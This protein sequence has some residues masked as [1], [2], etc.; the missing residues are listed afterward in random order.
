MICR[1]LSMLAVLLPGL[2]FAE[3][4]IAIIIDDIGYQRQLGERAIALDPAITLAVIPRSPHAQ[5]LARQA[6]EAGREVMIHLPMSASFSPLLDPGGI[7][8]GMAPENIAAVVREAFELVPGARGLNNHMGSELTADQESMHWLM[9][10]LASHQVFFVDSR[11]TPESVAERT[12]RAHGLA[13]AGRDV[14]LDNE[15]EALDIN[16]QFNTLLRIA[17]QRG[18]AIAIG[19]PYPE[20]LEYLETIIP[21]LADAGFKLVPVS[22]LLPESPL[23]TAQANQ[24]ATEKLA[25]EASTTE[26]PDIEEISSQEKRDSRQA[27]RSGERASPP[28]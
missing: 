17:R 9:H 27:Q 14:F 11:T 24:L 20:T 12:A 18:Q 23:H 19:H 21:L 3:P 28:G 22:E 8:P 7:R 2:L 1:A 26:E 25:A 16:S 6:V 10:E 15:R 13:A 4:R 5:P